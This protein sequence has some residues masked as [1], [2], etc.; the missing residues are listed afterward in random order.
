MKNEELLC[1][2]IAQL[3]LHSS[4][5]I[6]HLVHLV[7]FSW[8]KSGEKHGEKNGLIKKTKL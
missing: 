7:P 3:I 6:L 4:F 1:S 5:I 2:V 8:R